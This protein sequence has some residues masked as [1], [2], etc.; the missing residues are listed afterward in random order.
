MQGAKWLLNK[1]TSFSAES[2]IAVRFNF[3][4]SLQP[5]NECKNEKKKANARKKVSEG[6]NYLSIYVYFE[7]LTY[8]SGNL[9]APRFCVCCNY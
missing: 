9:Y 6:H 1:A 2:A 4:T 8:S 7:F 5:R 3:V